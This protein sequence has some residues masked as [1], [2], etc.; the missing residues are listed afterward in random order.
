MTRLINQHPAIEVK[1]EE[2]ILREV[3]S[4]GRIWT[5]WKQEREVPNVHYISY[6]HTYVRGNAYDYG[7]EISIRRLIFIGA[8]Q[9]NSCT[10]IL[11][12]I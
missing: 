4:V 3:D 8:Y 1:V 7:I 6:V 10:L 2:G 11:R 9:E 5:A 12:A